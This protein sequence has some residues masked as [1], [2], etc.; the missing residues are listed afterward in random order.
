MRSALPSRRVE[1][2][3]VRA[4]AAA[5]PGDGPGAGPRQAQPAHGAAGEGLCCS[6]ATVLA[7][8]SS[9]LL[10]RQPDMLQGSR[11]L[12]ICCRSAASQLRLQI[13]SLCLFA[14]QRPIEMRSTPS[15]QPQLQASEKDCVLYSAR[16]WTGGQEVG[17]WGRRWECAAASCWASLAAIVAVHFV[18]NRRSGGVPFSPKASGS[19]GTG[20]SSAY[21]PPSGFQQGGHGL[22]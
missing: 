15:R 22:Y 17:C 4:G 16:A 1:G 21:S 6:W 3:A 12:A 19:Y 8:Q 9:I 5:R 14:Q 7:L 2:A 11:T 10:R 20:L 13:D 18:S